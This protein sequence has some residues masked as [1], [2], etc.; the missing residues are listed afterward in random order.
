MNVTG[1]NEDISA[2]A[3]PSSHPRGGEFFIHLVGDLYRALPTMPKPA[4]RFAYNLIE[5][6][7]SDV[8]SVP[9]W[10]DH[11]LQQPRRLISYQMKRLE[12]AMAGG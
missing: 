10:G 4:K 6:L 7:E 1:N 8:L 3:V 2:E 5:L 9:A 11:P 12:Q